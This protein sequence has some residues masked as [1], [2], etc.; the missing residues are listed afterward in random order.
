MDRVNLKEDAGNILI[1]CPVRNR[2]W[3]LPDYLRSLFNLDYPKDKIALHFILNDSSDESKKILRNWKES[4]EK[5]Y[6]YIRISEVNFGYPSDWG[7][8]RKNHKLNRTSKTYKTLSVLRNLIL[9]IAWLDMKADYL[10]SVDSDILVKPDVLNK[11]LETRKDIVAALVKTS[12]NTYNFIPW[13]GER[14]I[15]PDNLFSVAVTGAVVLISR[16]VFENKKIR[17]S[18]ERTGEDEGFCISASLHGYKSYVLPEL[19]KHIMNKNE[20][21]GG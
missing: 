7:E 10:F 6:R 1:A 5:D 9:D 19:Q 17:Y 8:D 16:K 11:L 4:A 20:L 2:G 3:I 14:D 15:I 13:S 21:L 12:G 18:V